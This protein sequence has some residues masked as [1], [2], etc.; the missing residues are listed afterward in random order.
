MVDGDIE[1]SLH[2]LGV[3]VHC[4]NAVHSGCDQKIRDQ[5]RRNRHAWFIFS[6]LTRVSEKWNHCSDAIGAGPSRRVH[7]DEQLHQ[8]VVSWWTRWL[9]D[10]NV[11]TENVLLNSDVGLTIRERADRGLTQRHADVIADPLS[12]LAIG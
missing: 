5:F 11:A 2:L 12:Q 6:I 9:N 3:Q 8:V 4:Q 1:K 7:H 10:E